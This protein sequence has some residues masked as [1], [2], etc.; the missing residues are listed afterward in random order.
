MFFLNQGITS[1]SKRIITTFESLAFK[2]AVCVCNVWSA[3]PHP[4]HPPPPAKKGGEGEKRNFAERGMMSFFRECQFIANEASDAQWTSD[5]L[6]PGSRHHRSTSIQ[7]GYH[8]LPFGV[9]P[10][11]SIV[12]CCPWTGIWYTCIDVSLTSTFTHILTLSDCFLFYKL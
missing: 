8:F 3:P 1:A 2:A 4:P 7:C 6:H 9:W 5:T 12:K 10:W 11:L